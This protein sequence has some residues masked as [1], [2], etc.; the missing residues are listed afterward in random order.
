M[1]GYCAED[2]EPWIVAG[3]EAEDS[4]K[5][6]RMRFAGASKLIRTLPL[7]SSP[8]AKL[9]SSKLPSLG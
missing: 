3:Q 9:H 4:V 6:W 2:F 1:N 7:H 5:R 8:T